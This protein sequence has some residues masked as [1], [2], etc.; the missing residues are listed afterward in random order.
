MI[1]FARYGLGENVHLNE[2]SLLVSAAGFLL[3][4]EA[5]LLQIRFAC[6]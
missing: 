6:P 1:L 4:P 3:D 2:E 5:N